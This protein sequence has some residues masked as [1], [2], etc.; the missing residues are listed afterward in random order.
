M[1]GGVLNIISRKLFK[2]R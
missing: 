2:A 1:E